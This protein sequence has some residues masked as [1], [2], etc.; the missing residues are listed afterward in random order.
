LGILP[1]VGDRGLSPVGITVPFVDL[2]GV[3]RDLKESVLE[4][5]ADLIERGDFTNGA[6]VADFEHAFAAYCGARYCVGMSSGLDALRLALIA[7]GLR[8]GDEVIVPAFTFAATFEAVTQ[9]GGVPVVVDVSETDYNLDVAK[10]ESAVGDRTRFLLP[11]HLYGQMSDVRALLAL[12]ERHD[13]QIIED[14]CQAHGAVRDGIAS[15]A[16]G[17]AGA[18]SFYPAKNL[19][20]MGDAGALIT[21]DAELTERT[22]AL[23]EHGQYAKYEHALEGYT[24]RLDTIQA[25]VLLRKLSFLSDWNEERRNIARLYSDALDGVGDLRLPPVPQGSEPV[26]YVYVIRT[27]EPE[28]LANFLRERGIA[29]GRHYPQP[30]HLALAYA[31]LGHREEDF[32]VAERLAHEVLSLPIY[33]G[34]SESQLGAVAKTIREY[35]RG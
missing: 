17:L 13:L 20:A 27:A 29:T 25:L 18:F 9:A 7:G 11:V 10:A 33:P 6:A 31:D 5:V 24:A 23:R 15:G 3:H 21:N 19:G 28:R 2:G 35:F 30:P 14:A 12:A 22:R 26:W 4:S 16:G 34:V 32:P 1:G 8:T